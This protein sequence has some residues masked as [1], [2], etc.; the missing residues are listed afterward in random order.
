M[1]Y[2]R[3]EALFTPA[4]KRFLK[5]IDGAIGDDF[6][7]FGKVRIADVIEVSPMRNG[8]DWWRA[9][10]RISSKHLDYV[11]CDRNSLVVLCA[12]ELDDSSHARPDR[13]ERDVFVDAVCR[14]AG[15]PLLR[16]V[17]KASYSVPEVR[18][19][20]LQA[21][22]DQKTNVERPAPRRKKAARPAASK[23]R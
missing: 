1:P 19:R 15:V 5:A 14:A 17:N 8:R 2:R 4:E 23:R 21:I 10:T 20:I 9:F 22:R 12:I 3:R 11:I 6:H 13:Q 7:L 16:F 18:S